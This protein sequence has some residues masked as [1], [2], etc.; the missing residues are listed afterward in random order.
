MDLKEIEKLIKLCHKYS[1][2]SISTPEVSLTI[3]ALSPPKSKLKAKE[4]A[5]PEEEPQY[6]E[7]E[8]LMWSAGPI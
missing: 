3:E 2:K 6:T 5:V 4:E 1:V 7:E 8:I